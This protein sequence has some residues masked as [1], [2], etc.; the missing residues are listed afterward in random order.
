MENIKY[1]LRDGGAV[2]VSLALLLLLTAF[3]SLADYYKWVDES[4]QVH[5]TQKPPPD[6]QKH[7]I[8]K[9]T[10]D[11]HTPAPTALPPADKGGVRHCGSIT[12]PAKR[13]DSVTSIAMFRQAIAIWQKY[14]DENAGKSDEAIQQ[15]IKDRTC[16][17]AYANSELQALSE[18][19]QGLESNYQ[20]V[21]GELEELQQRVK[22]CDDPDR[23][24]EEFSAA[25]CKRQHQPRIAQLQKILRSL[26]G[27][28]K[29]LKPEE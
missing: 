26:E 21:S 29:V 10:V 13:P 28:R 25:E 8:E 23:A 14:L 4:G 7:Q 11:T 16:A 5:Y 9:I 18:V 6:P 27:T 22:E 3:P 2:R 15:G 24:D 17:I 19:E 1:R 12:L 20:S